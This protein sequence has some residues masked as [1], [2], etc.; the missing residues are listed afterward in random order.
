MRT[1]HEPL[2]LVCTNCACRFKRIR[3]RVHPGLCFCTRKCQCAYYSTH[4]ICAWNTGRKHPISIETRRKISATH[5]QRV[6]DG[7][8]NL[9]I[10][11][12]SKL[13]PVNERM[14]AEYKIWRTSVFER[15]HFTCQVCHV[16][17]CYLEAHHLKRWVDFPE[18]RFEVDNG[19]TL[20][21]N[22]HLNTRRLKAA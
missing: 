1:Q 20:C 15:D 17:G 3:Q 14:C 19:Q 4:K 11:G 2:D 21:R 18:L 7:V 6:A 22:C 5:K 8:S 12:R 10:D 13:K 16:K 9:Y